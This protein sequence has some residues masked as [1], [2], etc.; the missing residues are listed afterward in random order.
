MCSKQKVIISILAVVMVAG[1]YP[2][3]AGAS[4]FREPSVAD[5]V[6]RMG[7]SEAKCTEMMEKMKNMT[8]EDRDAMKQRGPADGQNQSPKNLGEN[9]KTPDNSKGIMVKSGDSIEA[10][11]KRA[12][13][14]KIEKEDKFSRTEE[15][16]QAIIDFLKSKT[17]DTSGLEEN[18]GEFKNKAEAVAGA[19]EEYIVILKNN[20]ISDDELQTEITVARAKIKTLSIELANFYRLTLRENIRLKLEELKD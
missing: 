6:E 1:F 5:C 14:I 15:R 3:F 10:Q 19:F 12:E 18:L 2:F 16:I 20:S 8:S 4:D 13:Q 11:L 9:K 17:V 7:M